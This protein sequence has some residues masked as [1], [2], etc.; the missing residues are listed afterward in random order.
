VPV[1]RRHWLTSIAALPIALR[2]QEG[3]P[4]EDP[5]DEPILDIEYSQDWRTCE[6]WSP[7]VASC[8]WANSVL[9]GIA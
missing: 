4:V 1:N 6:Y 5:A 3:P 8:I 7:H 2:A 9:E